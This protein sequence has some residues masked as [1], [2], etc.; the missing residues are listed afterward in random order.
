MCCIFIGPWGHLL[1][2]HMS[3]CCL[4]T[5]RFLIQP[6]GLPNSPRMSDIYS[7]TCHIFIW[8]HGLPRLY[9]VP[10]NKFVTKEISDRHNQRCLHNYSPSQSNTANYYLHTHQHNRLTVPPH[11]TAHEYTHQ[12]TNVHCIKPTELITTENYHKKSWC[13]WYSHAA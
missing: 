13:A 12:T 11:R 2:N 1:F 6:R 10:N 8:L 7:S 4:S 5:F 9:H 3:R